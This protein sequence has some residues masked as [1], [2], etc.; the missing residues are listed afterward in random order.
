VRF[1]YTALRNLATGHTL[2]ADYEIAIPAWEVD[3]EFKP[4]TSANTSLN[5][6]V[7]TELYRID[8]RWA[9]LTDLIDSGQDLENFEEF[10]FSV[11]GGEDFTFDPDSD[12]AT[13]AVNPLSCI[14]DT[15]TIRRRR[16]SPGKFQFG[17]TVLQIP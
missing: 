11:S 14:L 9:V 13:V 5:G 17:F 4:E 2:S 12:V 7:E 16:P 8:T 3:P 1:E 10:L 6:Q 15:R